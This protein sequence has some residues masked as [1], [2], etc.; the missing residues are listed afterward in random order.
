MIAHIIS[1]MK[2]RTVSATSVLLFIPNLIGYARVLAALA[3]FVVMSAFPDFWAVGVGLYLA[4]FVGDLFDGLLAR[5]LDQCSTFGS[6]LDML[7]DRCSTLGL[8]MILSVEYSGDDAELGFPLFR[9]LFLSLAI[10]DVSSHWAQTYSALVIG[11]HHKSDEGNVG[12]NFLVRWFYKYLWFFGYLCVGAEFTYVMLFVR[13]HLEL[14]F[15]DL[16]L[17]VCVPGCIAKQ[18]VNVAQ[19]LSACGAIARR[20]AEQINKKNDKKQ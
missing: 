14:L 7:T 18:F 19:L 11:E 5:K 6:V 3:S 4:S 2:Q 10:L 9:L 12:K 13:K 8:F 20:D 16:F 17:V 1:K 15:L